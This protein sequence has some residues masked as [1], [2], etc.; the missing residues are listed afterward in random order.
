MRVRHRRCCG[1]VFA[2]NQLEVMD[3]ARLERR[4]AVGKVEPAPMRSSAP[5]RAQSPGCTLAARNCAVRP[6]CMQTK[7]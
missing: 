4:L 5:G 1:S 3:V 7:G 2:P 6:R